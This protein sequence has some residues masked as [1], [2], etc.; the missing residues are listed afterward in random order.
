MSRVAKTDLDRTRYCIMFLIAD[1]AEKGEANRLAWVKGQIHLLSTN[2]GVRTCLSPLIYTNN[3]VGPIYDLCGTP[4]KT[5]FQLETSPS[6]TAHCLLSVSHCSIQLIIMFPT[7]RD[8]RLSIIL[9]GEHHQIFS[10]C[11]IKIMSTGTGGTHH[12]TILVIP[13]IKRIKFVRHYVAFRYH[14]E[15]G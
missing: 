13:S 14:A 5:N 3:K 9:L 4:L 12:Q 15:K 10:E 1:Q 2:L 11:P 6:T 7:P 8:F